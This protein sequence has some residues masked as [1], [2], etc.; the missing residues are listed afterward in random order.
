MVLIP[1]CMAVSGAAGVVLQCD[2]CVKLQ[3]QAYHARMSVSSSQHQ[4]S[5]LGRATVTAVLHSVSTA[6]RRS[7]S[8]E[9]YQLRINCGTNNRD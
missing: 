2:V 1:H 8:A 6:A 3:Q 5:P 4:W 9:E 7:S